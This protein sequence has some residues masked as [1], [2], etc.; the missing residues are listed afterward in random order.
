M[1]SPT[2]AGKNC[3]ARASRSTPTP[4]EKTHR[5]TREKNNV[6]ITTEHKV[7][8]I[9]DKSSRLTILVFLDERLVGS[10]TALSGP[11]EDVQEYLD[12]KVTLDELDERWRSNRV[13]G[14]IRAQRLITRPKP[15]DLKKVGFWWSENEPT[16]PKVE[17]FIDQDWNP[18]EREIVQRYLDIRGQPI[19]QCRGTSK[20]RICGVSNG[21]KDMSDGHYI[22]PSGLIHYLMMHQVKPA[23]DFIAHVL[24]MVQPALRSA[25]PE[26]EEATE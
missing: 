23:D 1:Y 16:L 20:C 12:G 3:T 11:K 22:W 17:S 9:G 2:R 13:A 5:P 18:Q 21:S 19:N 8:P 24:G 14:G 4:G 6:K 26:A 15:A 7:E 25:A 10:H